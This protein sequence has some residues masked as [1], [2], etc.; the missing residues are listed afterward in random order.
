M[1][2]DLNPQPTQ[3]QATKDFVKEIFHHEDFEKGL[4]KI[5]KCHSSLA[6]I[7]GANGLLLV[8]RSGTGKTT[9]LNV[10]KEFI[11]DY[12][13]ISEEQTY[14]M[15]VLMFGL[16]A[17]I[18][19]LGFARKAIRKLGGE[20]PNRATEPVL[21]EIL[22]DLLKQRRTE[23]I[24]LDEF[25]HLLRGGTK[26]Q[27]TQVAN[28]LKIL[29]DTTRIPMVLAGNEQSSA[30][31]QENAELQ[32]RFDASFTMRVMTL[33]AED[34]EYCCQILNF[35]DGLLQEDTCLCTRLM[36]VRFI[37]ASNGVLS[38]IFKIIE[39]AIE[40]LGS[41]KPIDLHA[42]SKGFEA[43]RN[44]ETAKSFDPFQPSDED[45]KRLFKKYENGEIV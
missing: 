29:L 26:N 12:H 7:N 39:E 10:Y 35:C 23:I 16:E 14:H 44:E 19:P 31:L 32:R 18:T 33:N 1:L 30:V 22:V 9:L 45:I 43:A 28:C 2:Q 17:Q 8:G 6:K 24:F 20:A 11:E 21:F 38:Y 27:I 42:L 34:V 36:A 37:L 13:N 4:K 15:P 5:N 3:L 41:N 40:F 25:H